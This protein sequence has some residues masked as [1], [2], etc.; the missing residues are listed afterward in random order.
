MALAQ[1]GGGYQLD[2]GNT[3]EAVMSSLGIPG[4]A[5]TSAVTLTPAELLSGMVITNFGSALALTT[6]TGVDLDTALGNAKVGTAFM[7]TIVG[8]AAFANTLTAGAGVTIVGSA[9][10]PATTIASAT[11]SFRKTGVGTWSAYRAA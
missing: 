10:T 1:V 7:F 6:P 9:A 11:W 8:V 2:D 4:A 5:K 3:S